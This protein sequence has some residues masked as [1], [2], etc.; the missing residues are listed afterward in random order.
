M[1]YLSHLA[2]LVKEGGLI[3]CKALEP[4]LWKV[5][6]DYAPMFA[7]FKTRY[8]RQRSAN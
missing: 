2:N 5:Y 7:T 1:D 4:E 6:S 8:G 3:S